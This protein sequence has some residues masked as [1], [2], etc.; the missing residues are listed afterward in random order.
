MLETLE[1]PW[2]TAHLSLGEEGIK[3]MCHCHCYSGPH[4]I[5]FQTIKVM[6]CQ[7]SSMQLYLLWNQLS[8]F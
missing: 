8:H 3:F 1:A 7:H 5:V 2:Y 6:S 4:L